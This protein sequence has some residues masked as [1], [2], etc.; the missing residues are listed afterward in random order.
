MS[1]QSLDYV[2]FSWSSLIRY[3]DEFIYTC[4]PIGEIAWSS[5]KKIAILDIGFY[6]HVPR[7]QNHCESIHNGNHILFESFLQQDFLN[8]DSIHYY[9]RIRNTDFQVVL[10]AF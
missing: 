10:Y 2:D 3:L 5:L 9:R 1:G 8:S 7:Y 4:Y 6:S